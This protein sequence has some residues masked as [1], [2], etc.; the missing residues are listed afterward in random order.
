[1][2]LFGKDISEDEVLERYNIFEGIICDVQLPE[3]QRRQ[4]PARSDARRNQ[5][6]QRSDPDKPERLLF[7]LSVRRHAQGQAV[8]HDVAGRHRKSRPR[9]HRLL[10]RTPLQLYRKRYRT[11]L[12]RR[13]EAERHA[14][15]HD[16]R[17]ISVRR[18]ARRI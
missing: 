9:A 16:Q 17:N 1:M 4:L 5:G 3:K 6:A 13:V 2:G 10:D 15:Q 7:L 14:L 12:R 11:G 8:R 18:S